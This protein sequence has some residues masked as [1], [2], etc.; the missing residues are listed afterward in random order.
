MLARVSLR[1]SGVGLVL[2]W[3]FLSI[4]DVRVLFVGGV[5]F[6]LLLLDRKEKR[7]KLNTC[8]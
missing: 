2:D 4:G 3:K 1:V 7:D 5:S 6:A 8:P